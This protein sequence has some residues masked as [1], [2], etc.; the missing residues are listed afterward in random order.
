MSLPDLPSLILLIGAV[1]A[2]TAGAVRQALRAEKLDAM[3][4]RAAML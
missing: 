4:P 1:A 2:F 3:F